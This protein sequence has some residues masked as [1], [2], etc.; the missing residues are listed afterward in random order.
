[1]KVQR[2]PLVA[3]LAGAFS[4][5]VAATAYAAPVFTV[6][7]S[8]INGS[9]LG[10]FQA[11]FISGNSSELLTATPTGPNSGTL[12][13]KGWV[14]FT[15]FSNGPNLVPS[16][17]SGLG[18]S[19][20][21]LYLTYDISGTLSSGMLGQLGSSYQLTQLDVK[22]WADPNFDTLFTAASS[23]GAGTT[24]S[25]AVGLPDMLLGEGKLVTGVGG[26][27]SLRG[28]YMNSIETFAL[29][30]GAG[31]AQWGGTSIADANCTSDVGVKYFIAP[32][33]FYS[34]A[35]DEFNNTTQGITSNG[36]LIA[37][38]NA[39]GG[40]DFAIPEPETLSLMGLALLGAG[41]SRRRKS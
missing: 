34:M 18:G 40:V 7:P 32:V 33:P 13:G 31:T 8:A 24:P 12:S 21:N 11:D 22:V 10:T 9:P 26:L 27:D 37:I 35:F 36:P 14:Q 20:Y 6:S 39:S 23:A 38:N 41:I 28:A 30:S 5:A 16:V 2:K 17:K 25:A 29:C 19:S 4:M 15:S 3:I 1:M